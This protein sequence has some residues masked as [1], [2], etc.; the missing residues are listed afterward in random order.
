MRESVRDVNLAW[1]EHWLCREESHSGRLQVT[2]EEL[3]KGPDAMQQ[4]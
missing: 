4:F 2:A 3:K 1:A